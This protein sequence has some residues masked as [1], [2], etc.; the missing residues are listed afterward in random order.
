MAGYLTCHKFIIGNKMTEFYTNVYTRGDKI[1]VR[2]YEDGVAFSRKVDFQPTLF[3]SSNTGIPAKWHT[4]YGAPVHEVKPG[5]IKDTRD[6]LSTYEDVAGFGV[7]GNSNYIHQYISET[8]P[9]EIRWDTDNVKL[10]TLDLETTTEFG[11]P[12]I[13]TANEEITLISLQNNFTKNIITFGCKAYNNTR[14]DVTYHLCNDEQHLL[15]EFLIFWQQNYPDALTGWNVNLF[16]VPYIINR[17]RRVLGETSA[18]RLSPWNIIKER[19]VTIRGREE[20]SY[21]IAGVSVLDYLDLYRKFTYTTQESYRLDHIAGVELNEG[22]L[23]LPGVDFKDSYTNHW[24]IFVDY[25]IRD[26]ELVDRLEDKMKLIELIVTM[27]YNAKINYEDVFS[28]VKM[29]DAIIYNHLLQKNIVV[30]QKSHSQKVEA[31]EGA[32]VKDPI[33]GAHNWV[34]SFDL[35]SLYPHLIMQYNM[36]PETLTDIRLDVDVERL[37]SAEFKMPY[38]PQDLAVT[39]NGWCYRKDVRGFLPELME[40]MY[41]DRSKYKKQMLAVQQEFEK[42]KGNNNLRKEISRLNNMQMAGKIAL[43]SLYGALGNSWFRYFDLRMAEGITTSGQLS[44]RWMADRLNAFMNKTLKTEGEDFVIA[45][46]TDSIYLALGKLVEKTCPNKTTDQTIKYLD[47]IC[48]EVFMPFID[49]GYQELAEYMNAY[50]QKMQMKRE[51]LA[52]KAIWTAKKRYILNV[53]NSEGVQYAQPKLKVVGLEVNKSST[54]AIIRKKLK[55]TIQVILNKTEPELQKYIADF[56]E[57]FNAMPL[58]VIS[59]PRGV[60]NLKQYTGSPIYAKAT[61]IAVR[62]ALLHNHYIKKL[63]L[64]KQYQPILEG[65]KIKFIYLNPQNPIREDVIGYIDHLPKEFGLHEFIDYDKMFDKV[66][67]DAVKIILDAI[68]WDTEHRSSL[69]DFF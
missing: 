15:K 68:G 13:E 46:D 62:A 49:K 38:Y 60:N 6:F 8:Y 56:R 37:L 48:A 35:A 40:K 59:F 57:E 14:K 41:Q 3:V 26:V 54:P 18:S 43:N 28:P 34:A 39:A 12:N 33:I 19:R 1:L 58:E 50:Q 10:F 61:P 2:G 20:I 32:F 17:I 47:R 5:S 65:S 42:D 53:H 69:E 52:D 51:V 7:H 23:D 11:F 24:Q 4:L 67:V 21:D 30:P 16:D 66:Y 29:W 44:I 27:A 9:K 31:F 64:T 63:G 22:K 25:N 55:D 36:S 45:I